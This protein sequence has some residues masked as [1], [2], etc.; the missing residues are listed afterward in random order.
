MEAQHRRSA[1]WIQLILTPEIQP[2]VDAAI[3]CYERAVAQARGHMAPD[4]W[5]L[6]WETMQRLQGQVQALGDLPACL[7]CGYDEMWALS[8]ALR[9]YLRVLDQQ[10]ADPQVALAAGYCFLLR[11]QC[12]TLLGVQEVEQDG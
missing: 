10:P 9:L 2:V 8:I 4:K 12:L 7:W 1:P 5:T 3:H 6:A 11:H